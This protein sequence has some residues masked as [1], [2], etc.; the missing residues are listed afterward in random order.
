MPPATTTKSDRIT[1]PRARRR[2]GGGGPAAPLGRARTWRRVALTATRVSRTRSPTSIP[3][4]VHQSRGKQVATTD[5]D[6]NRVTGSV[7][8]VEQGDGG[9]GL[10]GRGPHDEEADDH[11]GE[12]HGVRRQPH[13]VQERHDQ[14]PTEVGHPLGAGRPR[15]PHQLAGLGQRAGVGHRDHDVVEQGP[16]QAAVGAAPRPLPQDHQG[17]RQ[18]RQETG[19][20]R[21]AGAPIGPDGGRSPRGPGGGSSG[22]PTSG[23][24]SST[25]CAP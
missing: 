25:P 3:R 23:A 6:R 8:P 9:P 19:Q 17:Q 7:A 13:P 20:H 16:V 15:E 18:R 5:T 2:P 14:G 24:R 11:D 10:Q 12:H 21:S 22:T 4:R 1:M